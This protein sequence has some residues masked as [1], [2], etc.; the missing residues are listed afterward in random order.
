MIVAAIP[1][2]GCG[3]ISGLDALNVPDATTDAQLSDEAADASEDSTPESSSLACTAPADC[4]DGG[5]LDAAY[6]PSSGEVCCAMLDTTG[7]PGHC[8][9][10]TYASH[11]SA[12]SACPSNIPLGCGAD[13]VRL[14]QHASECTEVEYTACCVFRD[15]GMFCANPVQVGAGQC[16]SA[17][18]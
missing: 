11:C 15:A 2:V 9:V 5:I 3:L 8:A 12:P 6:P 17:D 14:C 7:I 4:I 1:I 13:T 18:E 10:Q 16:L